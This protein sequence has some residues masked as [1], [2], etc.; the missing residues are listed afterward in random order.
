[1]NRTLSEQG[2]PRVSRDIPRTIRY[3]PQII[4]DIPRAVRYIPQIIR[5]IPRTVRYIPRIICDIPRM[6]CYILVRAIHAGCACIYFTISSYYL[7]HCFS[8][9]LRR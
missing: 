8:L 6:V 4:R 9:F 1:M 3:I 7:F 2:V 5:D